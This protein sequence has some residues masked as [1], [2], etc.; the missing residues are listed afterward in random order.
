MSRLSVIA[1]VVSVLAAG[2]SKN[3]PAPGPTPPP[4]RFVFTAALS[5]ANEVPPISNAENGA[6]GNA[7]ITMNVTRDGSNNITGA[8]VDVSST[9]TGMA[10]GSVATVAH[11]HTGAT[12]VAGGTLVN[13]IPAAG[14]VT[15]PNGSGSYVHT[16]F[17]VSPVDVANQIIANPA[18]YYFNIHTQL[19]PGGVV[20][21][22][23]VLQP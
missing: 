21:G 3:S 15:F 5:A 4:N 16:G 17:P 8:T 9:Y 22:Q 20:R 23:L 7:T 10:P 2:C 12:G 6:R 18:G 11:I 1:I 13:M 14:E 19:N